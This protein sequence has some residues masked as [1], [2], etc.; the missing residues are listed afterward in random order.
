MSL[1]QIKREYREKIGTLKKEYK[2]KKATLLQQREKALQDAAI[3]SGK[4][5]PID[6]PKRPLL[7][8]IGNA[9][10]HGVGALFAPFAFVLMLLKSDS[11]MDYLGASVYFFGLFVMFL[12]SCL[13]HS[14]KHGSTVK[15]IF[16]RFD[17]SSIYLLIGATFAPILL[18]FV[19]GI[20][21][22]V[23]FALQ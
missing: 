11:L 19:G 22:N 20:L 6:P 17:Y 14:F 12:M 21:G 3:Q 15:R 2:E 18:S 16:R 4:S 9:V 13:Y 23:Y 7:E 5:L 1:Q 10:T 8:E